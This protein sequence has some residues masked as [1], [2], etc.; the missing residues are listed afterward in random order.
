MIKAEIKSNVVFPDE[1][2]TQGDLLE[3]ANRVFI[4]MMVKGIDS[5]Q[6]I[7]GGPMPTLS[8]RTIK[9]KGH[10]RPLIDKGELRRAFYAIK[11]G[12]NEVMVSILGTRYDIGRKLQIEGVKS[13]HGKK[14]FRFFGINVG[15]EKSAVDFLTDKYR[16]VIR[17]FN[18]K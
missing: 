5:R 4:P 10:D 13:G 18:G 3:V 9:I 14:F 16:K 12:K 2:I 15:M 8:A 11:H 1:F 7:D 6:A 17:K